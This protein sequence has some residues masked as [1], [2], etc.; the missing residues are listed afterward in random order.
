MVES[1]F[2][3]ME[4]TLTILNV[5]MKQNLHVLM[6]LLKLHVLIVTNQFVQM[7][8]CWGDQHVRMEI[9]LHVL[10]APVL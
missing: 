1:Q 7:E 4:A 8:L 2:V 6:E 3:Q 10:M 5:R 9:D